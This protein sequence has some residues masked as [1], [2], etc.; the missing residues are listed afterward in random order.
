MHVV[1]ASWPQFFVLA[2]LVLGKVARAP[3]FRCPARCCPATQTH[4][5]DAQA[6]ALTRQL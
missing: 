3:G 2:V 5:R 1:P 4:S 6:S